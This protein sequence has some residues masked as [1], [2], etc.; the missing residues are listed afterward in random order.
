MN[1][2]KHLN[3]FGFTLVE[4]VVVVVIIVILATITIPALTK[5]F[6]K[7]REEKVKE[8]IEEL[9]DSCQVSFYDL[10]ASNSHSIDDN[11]VI[12][13]VEDSNK[14]PKSFPKNYWITEVEVGDCDIH[15]NPIAAS[16]L[17]KC[18][19]NIK[20]DTPCVVIVGL[21]RYDIYADPSSE[22]YEPTKAYTVYSMIYQPFFNGK[23][24]FYS[25][26][27]NTYYNP[28]KILKKDVNIGNK[29]IKTNYITIDSEEI[30]IQY[31]GIKLGK[32][33]NTKWDDIWN[34]LKNQ[35]NTYNK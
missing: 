19:L 29:T 4:I 6:T 22:L 14:D 7:S 13:G 23:V 17:K 11:C 16:I 20:E 31:Y 2:K 34:H 5:Y 28:N 33:N 3:N 9:M 27:K 15:W 35:A 26:G 30:Y 18:N 21:G 10:Y 12:S 25:D 8:A 1:T 24:Y 32:G